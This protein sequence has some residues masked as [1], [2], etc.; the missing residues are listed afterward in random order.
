MTTN[1]SQPVDAFFRATNTHDSAALLATFTENAVLYNAD[2][3]TYRGR[4]GI[5]I[6]N[7][8]EFVGAHCTVDI[9]STITTGKGEVIVT[10]DTRGDFPGN[11]IVLYFLFTI[12]GGL[13]T[14]LTIHH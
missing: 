4:D 9:A 3:G 13:I 1:T 7:D 10:G 6:W 11:Q 14:A 8:K 5:K 2:E 12:E